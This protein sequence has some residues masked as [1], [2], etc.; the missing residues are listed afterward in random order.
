MSKLL[1]VNGRDMCKILERLGF[2]KVH[3]VGSHV[4]YVHPDG[5]KT[6]VPVHGNENL[7]I[8]LI[9]EILKQT[10]ISREMYEELRRKV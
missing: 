5:R 10:R 1:P 9:K 6:V 2:Q 3:Q 7:G 8:G 4:R